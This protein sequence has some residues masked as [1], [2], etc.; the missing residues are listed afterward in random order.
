MVNEVTNYLIR[1]SDKLFLDCT[2]GEGGHSEEILTR[3]SSIVLYGLDRDAKIL[4]IARNRLSIFQNRIHLLNLNFK[5]VSLSKINK[6]GELFNS[7]LIDLGISMFHYKNSKRGFS[8]SQREKLDMRLDE[9]SINVY[10]IVNSFSEKELSDIF[11]KYGE[12]RFSR[13]I[14][15][16]IVVDRVKYKIEY[17]NQLAEIIAGA[18]PRKFWKKNIHPATKCF[19][20]LRIYANNELENIKIGIPKVLS[21]IKKGGRLGVITFHSLEDRLVKNIFN[22]LYKDCICPKEAPICTCGKKREIN[23]ILRKI[24]PS[25]EEIDK[26]PS[27][28]SSKL[29]I[30]EKV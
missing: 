11:F 19:Q 23:W 27:S 13:K 24:S 1:K 8:F 29:R 7:A 10:D 2:I 4:K 30:V 12:E 21:V 18:I 3:F 14:A 17:S 25:K 22:E 9:E 6:G 28:R 26:N 15:N 20:A 5:D 16:K